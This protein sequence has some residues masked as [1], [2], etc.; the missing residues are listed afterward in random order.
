MSRLWR[1]LAARMRRR[2]TRPS[3]LDSRTD[4]QR[5]LDEWLVAMRLPFWSLALVGGLVVAAPLDA[6]GIT[7]HTVDPTLVAALQGATVFDQK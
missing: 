7:V 4:W 2:P 5:R 1:A 3:K 6:S